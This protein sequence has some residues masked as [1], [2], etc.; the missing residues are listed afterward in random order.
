MRYPWLGIPFAAQRPER[1]VQNRPRP[2][3]AADRRP[4]AMLAAPALAL[5]AW[6]GVLTVAVV[7]EDS[8]RSNRA[9]APRDAAVE[10]PSARPGRAGPGIAPLPPQ[11]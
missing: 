9:A 2:A 10:G 4:R 6:V 3:R 1:A 5:T 8:S 7:E 11:R